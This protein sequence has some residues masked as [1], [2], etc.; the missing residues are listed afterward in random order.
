MSQHEKKIHKIIIEECP[1]YDK[2]VDKGDDHY[3]PSQRK[4]VDLT[5]LSNEPW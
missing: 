4:E 3:C 5:I 2:I 1:T